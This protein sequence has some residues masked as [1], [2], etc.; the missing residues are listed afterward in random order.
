[1]ALTLGGDLVD[2][3]NRSLKPADLAAIRKQLVGIYAKMDDR[4][5]AAGGVAALRLFA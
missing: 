4:G 1:M 2:D 3:E 5:I